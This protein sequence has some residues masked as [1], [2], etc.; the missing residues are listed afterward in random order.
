MRLPSHMRLPL[1][2]LAV[3]ILGGCA[4]APVDETNAS[5]FHDALFAPPSE[6]VNPARVF[7]LSD[8]MRRYVRETI[9]QDFEAK[10]RQKALFDAL[11]SKNQLRLEY[12]SALTR[13]AAQAFA[14]RAGNC[15][16]LAIMTAAFAKDLGLT[17]RYQRIFADESWSRNADMYFASG[18]V[19][20]TL[21]HKNGD[22]RVLFAERNLLT[23]DFIP[24]TDSQALRSYEVDERTIVAMYMNNR[25]AELLA[26]GRL[27]DAYWHAREAIEQDPRFVTAVNTLGVIYR[28]HDNLA[29]AEAVLRYALSREPANANTMSNLALVLQDLGRTAEARDMGEKVARLQPLA[30]FADFNRGMEAVRAGDFKLAR[31]LFAREVARDSYNSEFHFWLSV[32][33]FGLGD[34]QAARRELTTAIE[35]SNTRGE[36]DRYAAK[37][38]ALKSA[39]AARGRP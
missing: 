39:G 34:A 21:G 29:Q 36:H 10:G 18:H 6:P 19:N 8:E 27:D 11:Y 37:L 14:A 38:R 7:A 23:I 22:P 2:A 4:T 15:L 12:D 33:Y 3:A 20:I 24:L 26:K 13:T 25:A 35:N 30:P 9:A 17:V 1:A 5:L 28:R 16:S 32:A 31:E